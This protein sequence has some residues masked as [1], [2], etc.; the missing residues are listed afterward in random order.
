MLL[1]QYFRNATFQFTMDKETTLKQVPLFTA[2]PE[3]ELK[4]LAERTIRK[5]VNRGEL[6]FSE[7]EKAH[8]LYIVERGSVKVFKVAS[9]GRE[10]VLHVERSGHSFAEVP[11]FDG[12]PYPASAAALEDSVLLFI[13]KKSFD[14]LCLSHPHI[15]LEVIRVIGGRL[16]KLTRLIEEISL[17]DVGHRLARWLLERAQEHG[18]KQ[19]EAVEFQLDLSHGEI[20]TRIGTVREVVTRS[21]SRLETDGIIQISGRNVRIPNLKGLISMLEE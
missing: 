9:S 4:A 2:L 11:L 7:G 13:D 21:L 1:H 17:K 12:G 19:G 20:G 15:A 8:G 18:R 10:Q 5:S 14:S 16:R 3:K 6:L